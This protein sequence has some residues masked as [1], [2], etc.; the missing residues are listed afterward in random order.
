M[1]CNCYN[2][3][4]SLDTGITVGDNDVVLSDYARDQA[5]VLGTKS[6]ERLIVEP[7][8]LLCE[9]FKGLYLTVNQTVKSQYVTA[10]FVCN[11]SYVAYNAVRNNVFRRYVVIDTKLSE[12]SVKLVTLDLSYVLSDLHFV[13]KHRN[14]HI[15][16][17]NI[18]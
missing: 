10:S 1:R 15:F 17:V 6:F 13:C 7:F 12:H 11:S 16:F 5:V 4:S 8:L 18:G 9:K 3:I 14:D 2:V